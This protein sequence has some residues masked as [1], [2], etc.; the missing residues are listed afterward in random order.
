MTKFEQRGVELQQNA[1]TKTEAQRN[2]SH[3]CDICCTHGLKIECDR[4]C[5]ANCHKLIMALFA[6]KEVEPCE[7]LKA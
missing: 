1:I 3:S 2:F 6:D 7:N 4:C 5:I